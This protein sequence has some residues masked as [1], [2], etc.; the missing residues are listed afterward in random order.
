MSTEAQQIVVFTLAGEH[1]GLDIHKVYEIIM[2]PAITKIP[3]APEFVEGVINLR[4]HIVPVFDLRRRLELSP[5]PADDQTRIIIVEVASH[6]AGMI[7]DSVLEVMT[8]PDKAMEPPS[9]LMVS[10]ADGS[11]LEGVINLEE[12]LIIMVS[13]DGIFTDGERERLAKVG[14]DMRDTQVIS[15]PDV[16][17]LPDLEGA[18]ES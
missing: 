5:V 18:H 6:K 13:I 15:L 14:S 1:F 8:V 4:G 3:R 7:V 11:Y 17:I 16:S 9:P 12:Q 10:A 2:M